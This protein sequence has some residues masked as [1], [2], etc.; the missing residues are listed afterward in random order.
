MTVA[1]AFPPDQ[2]PGYEWLDNEPTFD[3]NVHLALEPPAGVTMLAELGYDPPGIDGTATG[4]A[5]S[6]PF[7][8]LSH[9]GAAV[10]LDI[11][12]RLRAFA[13]PAGDRIEH[14]VR[15]GCYRSRWLRD[16]CISPDV[17]ELM[18]GIYGAEVAPHTMPAHLG[19]LN[20]EPT[21]LEDAVDKWHHD[22]I[23]LDY[24]MMVSDPSTL[25]GGRFEY[26]LGT[27][28]E[29]EAL[30]AAGR[31]PPPDRV[32][33]PDVPGPGWAIALHGNMVVHRG[34][35][36]TAP[37]E[38]I[39]MV[40]AYVAMDR[41]LGDQSR[42][43]DLIGVDDPASL[44]FEWVRHAA[45]RAEGR[46]RKLIDD[47]PFGLTADEGIAK[48]EAAIEDVTQAIDDMRAGQRAP[49]HYEQGAPARA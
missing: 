16:L 48:L 1:V 9:E 31:T 6:A 8:I 47:V 21:R 25:P 4:M 22:T 12:R 3:P 49:D 13:R 30:A 23:P 40:N 5:A 45:W 33:V 34:A 15:G 41:Q 42:S 39:T 19:H 32:V 44:Y 46:L 26:F 27:K 7:R 36:L 35:A 10:A 38:R 24:V 17:T 11:A 28:A 18:C 2:P 14:T 20:Y 29:A 37:A 43:R